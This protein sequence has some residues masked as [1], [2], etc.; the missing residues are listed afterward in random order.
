MS[1][2]PSVSGFNVEYCLMW[3]VDA[4]SEED[5]HR[6]AFVLTPSSLN[7]T[8]SCMSVS[9]HTWDGILCVRVCVCAR[10]CAYPSTFPSMYPVFKR[11]MSNCQIQNLLLKLFVLS[12]STDP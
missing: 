8:Q 6:S 1:F 9:N 2:S 12:Q 11:L 10:E 3:L 5:L 7:R 4:Y